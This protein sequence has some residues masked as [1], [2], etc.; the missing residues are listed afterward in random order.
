MAGL[1]D[2]LRR[3]EAEG[4]PVRVALV[5][6]GKFGGMFLAQARRTPGLHIVGVSDL[7]PDRVRTTLERVGWPAEQFAAEHPESAVRQRSTW[8]TDETS[9][10]LADPSVE[11]VVEAT[12][13]AAAGAEHA[14]LAIRH[15][16]HVVMVNVEADVLAGPLLAQQAQRA[17]VRYSLAYGDQPALI[18]ELVDWARTAGFP[19]IAAGKG[20]KHLPEYH[21]STPETVWGYFGIQE[22][23]AI[24][25][26][27]NPQM[28]NSFID[29][30]KSA[31]E[32]AAVANATGLTASPQGLAFPPCSVPELPTRLCPR[33]DGGLLQQAGQVEVVSCVYADG[34]PVPQ[35]L[36]WGVYVVFAAPD[37]HIRQC[38][39]EYGLVTDPSGRYAALHRPYHLVGMEL[40]VSI[41]SVV[42]R[43]E[44]TGC[45]IGFHADVV[46]I[47]K[48]NLHPGD[49][50]DGEGGYTVYGGLLP[51]AMSLRQGALP[52]GLAHGARMVAPVNA[53]EVILRSAV[54][55]DDS[56]PAVR[57]RREL[58]EAVP[59]GP[60]DA[61]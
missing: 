54:R 36:R 30:T 12:G 56:A 43:G 29:G 33:S 32:M 27:M 60:A 52:A 3:R 44:A 57:L 28:F 41:A 47:A 22:A 5:G 53:G 61:P 19:V 6:G 13:A 16:K 7:R 23:E 15:G 34:T 39:A 18:V 49:L 17:G 45:P 14:S 50:L 38:F 40:G 55:L 58:E 46:A 4:R 25:S 8:V 42:L 31:V 9:R 11:V 10:L 2:G 20:T 21:R 1:A 26:G 24:A 48:R 35:D 51:A 37:D 59:V